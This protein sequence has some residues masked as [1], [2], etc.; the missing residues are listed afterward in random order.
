MTPPPRR[1]VIRD[2]ESKERALLQILD[3]MYEQLTF[4]GGRNE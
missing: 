2:L 4:Q 1:A 3:G